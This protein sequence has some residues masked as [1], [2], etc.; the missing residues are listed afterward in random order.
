MSKERSQPFYAGANRFYICIENEHSCDRISF[1]FFMDIL[2]A[3]EK[4]WKFDIVLK[5]R[6]KVQLM[7][8]LSIAMKDICVTMLLDVFE[9]MAIMNADIIWVQ[10]MLRRN[11]WKAIW[12]YNKCWSDISWTKASVLV[13][14]LVVFS[15]CTHQFSYILLHKISQDISQGNRKLHDI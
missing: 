7:N 11:G 3:S 5:E 6:W 9:I 1:P 13:F 15:C 4:L 10:T 2:F 8:I 12:D 14:F